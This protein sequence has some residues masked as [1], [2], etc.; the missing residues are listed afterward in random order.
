MHIPDRGSGHSSWPRPGVLET[1]R[2]LTRP[3]R[4][5]SLRRSM[6]PPSASYL[7][8]PTVGIFTAA[9]NGRLPARGGVRASFLQRSCSPMRVRTET[10]LQRPMQPPAGSRLQNSQRSRSPLPETN[11]RFIIVTARIDQCNST[12]RD[13]ANRSLC[14]PNGLRFAS[15]SGSFRTVM[16]T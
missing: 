12:F 14:K 13:D 6:C 3:V 8:F 7:P 9:R 4:A 16:R 2:I 15:N 1:E 5:V 11:R 10:K